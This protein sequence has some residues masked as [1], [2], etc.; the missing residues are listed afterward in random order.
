MRPTLGAAAVT[1]PFYR[2]AGKSS[3]VRDLYYTTSLKTCYTPVMSNQPV[4]RTR[5]HAY[6]CRCGRCPQSRPTDWGFIGPALLAIGAIAVFG[7]W[8]A[9]F[10]HGESDTGGYTWTAATTYAVLAWDGVLAFIAGI[11]VYGNRR[12]P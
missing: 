3:P 11:V 12:T 4:Y 5:N 9:F 10:V 2:P 8:P 1:C 7:F 6:S